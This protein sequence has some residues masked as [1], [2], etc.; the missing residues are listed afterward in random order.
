[1]PDTQERLRGLAAVVSPSLV[2]FAT[3]R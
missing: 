1:V 3:V 2:P